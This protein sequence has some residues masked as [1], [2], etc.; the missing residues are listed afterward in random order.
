MA[1][2]IK[3]NDNTWGITRRRW[4]MPREFL[5]RNNFWWNGTD[6]VVKYCKFATAAEAEM[7][8]AVTEPSYTVIREI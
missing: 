1:K 8:Y 3:F 7:A 4:L 5:G 6:Y 2:L